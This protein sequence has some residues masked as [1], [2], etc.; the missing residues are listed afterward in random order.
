MEY[1]TKPNWQ[2]PE[3]PEAFAAYMHASLVD[4]WLS[5]CRFQVYLLYVE[6]FRSP[7]DAALAWG[8]TIDRVQLAEKG[9]FRPYREEKEIHDGYYAQKIKGQ[10]P[11]LPETRDLLVQCWREEAALVESWDESSQKEELEQAGLRA[12]D[13][14]HK[15]VAPSI[16]PQCLHKDF[17]LPMEDG[18]WTLRG[19]LDFTVWRKNK[20]VVRELKTA[21][22]AWPAGAARNRPQTLQYSVAAAFDPTLKELNVD[23]DVCEYEIHTKT[24]TPKIQEEVVELTD[25]EREAYLITVADV[26]QEMMESYKRGVFRPNRQCWRCSRR[27]CAFWALCEHEWGGVV[28]GE[29][30]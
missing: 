30:V 26:R 22:R 21:K 20:G 4:N 28:K 14:W 24:K 7:P 2:K 16:E 12:V 15:E 23:P 3:T 11:P 13:L 6:G 1:P 25:R 27:L 8:T 19:S 10:A 18:S 9:A 5:G 29:E 17:N